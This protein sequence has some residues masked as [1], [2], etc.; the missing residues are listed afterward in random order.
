M[1]DDLTARATTT[2]HANAATIWDALTDPVQIKQYM[3]G[4]DVQ[5]GWKEGSAIT[6]KGEWQ[7]KAY[8]DRGEIVKMI[9]NR[10]LQYTHYSPLGGQPDK[11]ENYHTVTIDLA[12]NGE[13][14]NV[15]LAQN[16]NATEEAREHSAKN[17]AM[18]LDGLKKMIE[19][20]GG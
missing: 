15:A 1:A 18:M 13:Q 12:E 14:T 10:L 9:P 4:T 3:F 16:G 17:W 5:S 8:E 7:G 19:Q 11:P 20:R 2:I 6:W